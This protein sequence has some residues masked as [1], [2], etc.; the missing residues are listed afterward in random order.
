[1][2]PQQTAAADDDL[3]L[4]LLVKV[5]QDHSVRVLLDQKGMRRAGIVFQLRHVFATVIA[6]AI[7][8]H[9]VAAACL[10]HR[11]GADGLHLTVSENDLDMFNAG[12]FSQIVRTV[13][14]PAY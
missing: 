11:P 3:K 10:L 13:Q 8:Q 1:M 12:Q 9:F 6:G 2:T 14:R 5:R 7:G 4:V